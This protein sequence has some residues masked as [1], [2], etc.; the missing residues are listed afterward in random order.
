M[1]VGVSKLRRIQMGRETV[2]GTAVAATTMW[3]GLGTIK[4]NREVVFP[5]EHVGY[6]SGV[7]RSY[8]P[9][10]EANI[11]FDSVP[12]T[13]EQLPH[14]FEAGIKTDTPAQDGAGTG[15][16]Y[17][18]PFATT[19]QNTIKTYTIEGGDN[20][21]AEEMEYAFVDSFTLSGV[22]GEAWMVSANWI[23]RQVSKTT[24]TGSL[25]PVSVEEMI[26]GK[27]KLYIDA[28]D[29]TI[30]STQISDTLLSAEITFNNLNTPVYTA[31]GYKYLSFTKQPG[32]E[33]TLNMVFE[34][35]SGSVAQKDLW[36]AE[37]PRLIRLITEGSAL[38]TAAT[39]TY[40][41]FIQ[42]YAGKYAMFEKIDEQNGNDII[43]A[44]FNARYNATGDLFA[45]LSVVNELSALP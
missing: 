11:S 23:G 6:L 1:T 35:N 34:H 28:V 16:L 42:D 25:S 45:Q 3:R 14:I 13:F 40:K 33:I 15:Y 43:S 38:G 2:A 18:Y 4:D 29:G 19:S 9:K 22:A 8:T 7:D 5:D 36:V 10:L 39:Y 30:G 20:I 21:Q 26:F 24:F 44:T 37:T 31:N 32:A 12:A 41:T 27:T 17:E